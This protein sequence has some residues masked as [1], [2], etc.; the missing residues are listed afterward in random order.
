[1]VAKRWR[2]RRSERR[3]RVLDRTRR[4]APQWLLDVS[5]PMMLYDCLFLGGA[6]DDAL[7]QALHSSFPRLSALLRGDTARETA[8][9]AR[10]TAEHLVHRDQVAAALLMD[11]DRLETQ[12]VDRARLYTAL[13][14]RFTAVQAGFQLKMARDATPWFDRRSGIAH[15]EG[16][17][18]VAEKLS[19]ALAEYD[20][21]VRAVV[22][23][24]MSDPLIEA[25]PTPPHRVPRRCSARRSRPCRTTPVRRCPA[26]TRPAPKG[27]RGR[28]KPDWPTC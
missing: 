12:P 9:S 5:P 4:R 20:A 19:A 8:R 18:R 21:A 22:Y 28:R 15:L 11:A 16:N 24:H 25:L 10:S 7:Q 14:A 23:P 13:E 6:N 26:K 2:A 3:I 1:M 27:R 17:L